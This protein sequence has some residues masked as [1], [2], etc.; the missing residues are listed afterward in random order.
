MAWA[1]FAEVTAH[2]SSLRP[3]GSS[4]LTVMA[5]STHGEPLGFIEF[6]LSHPLLVPIKRIAPGVPEDD[7]LIQELALVR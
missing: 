7:D 2:T 3:A 1:S 4:G 6:P 5:V